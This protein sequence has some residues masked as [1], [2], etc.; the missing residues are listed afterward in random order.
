M[1][2]REAGTSR[3]TNLAHTGVAAHTDDLDLIKDAYGPAALVMGRG[4]KFGKP[5]Q[6]EVVFRLP[7]SYRSSLCIQAQNMGRKKRV[8]QVL[9]ETSENANI[10]LGE[11]LV[12]IGER[13]AQT[14][15]GR[16]SE[17]QR[18]DVFGRSGRT[19][20]SSKRERV[21]YDDFQSARDMTA[22]RRAVSARLRGQLADP[23]LP[24]NQRP[25]FEQRVMHLERGF[26]SLNRIEDGVG[27]YVIM[28]NLSMGGEPVPAASGRDAQGLVRGVHLDELDHDLKQ[29]RKEFDR[30]RRSRV[31]TLR[32][33]VRNSRVQ[34][35]E[36]EGINK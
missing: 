12:D 29:V 20:Q 6:P 3:R 8:N 11:T 1:Y 5:Q 2:D 32:F 26:Y 36:R 13:A 27:R 25:R 10:T 31:R 30:T 35:S 9:K 19:R 17:Q 18:I 16:D 33:D 23:E 24:P 28:G 34:S 22:A 15:V 7:N 21:F 4:Y 14:N